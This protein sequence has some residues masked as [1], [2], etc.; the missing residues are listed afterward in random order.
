MLVNLTDMLSDAQKNKYAIPAFDISNYE[1]M[2]AVLDTC[3]ELRSPAL[4]QGLQ[5]DF[6]GRAMNLLVDMVKSASKYYSIPICLH[7]D[8][9]LD[10][11]YIKRRY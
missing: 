5:V 10:L 2:K 11:E 1:M 7:L 6:N 3:E 8:H 9:A 4:L